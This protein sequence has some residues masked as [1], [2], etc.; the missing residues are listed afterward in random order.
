MPDHVSLSKVQHRLGFGRRLAIGRR[1]RPR[2][3]G[4]SGLRRSRPLHLRKRS[5]PDHPVSGKQFL[6]GTPNLPPAW[7]RSAGISCTK[8]EGNCRG[9][10]K[11]ILWAAQVDRDALFARVMPHSKAGAL[12]P[13]LPPQ[14]PGTL[15]KPSSIPT[16]NT[17]GNSRPLAAC[18]VI[19]VTQLSASSTLSKS[20]YRATSS[21]NP[22]REGSS[23]C[24]RYPLMEEDNS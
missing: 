10:P 15:G 2:A 8:R 4:P 6:L 9:P 16:V 13:P 1:R 7:T 3:R 23:A 19:R 22:P 17:T 21:K 24:S 14:W 5:S 18:M 12:P 20:V 11:S